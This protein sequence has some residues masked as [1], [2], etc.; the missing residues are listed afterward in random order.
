MAFLEKKLLSKKDL[1]ILF[2]RTAGTR[3]Y[4]L[5]YKCCGLDNFT[6]YTVSLLQS[7]TGNEPT[8]EVLFS[9]GLQVTATYNYVNPGEYVVVFDKPIFNS[10]NDYATILGGSF[11]NG[12]DN[13]L[14]QVVPTFFNSILITSYKNGIPSDDVIGSFVPT[15]LDIRK[16]N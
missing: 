7:G 10:Q 3:L 2:G 14:V 4:N 5:I 6:S 16:Y 13:F 1:F 11:T 8:V 15:I 12:A 9:N